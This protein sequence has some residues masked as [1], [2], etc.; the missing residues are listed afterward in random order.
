[1]PL[2][3]Q[4]ALNFAQ[5]L[6]WRSVRVLWEQPAN[7]WNYIGHLVHR[8]SEGKCHRWVHFASC[9]IL[10]FCTRSIRIFY[11]I[12]LTRTFSTCF[13]GIS[14]L[15]RLMAKSIEAIIIWNK[16]CRLEEINTYHKSNHARGVNPKRSSWNHTLQRDRRTLPF[17]RE[18][19]TN[20]V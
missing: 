1:M 14:E 10:Y 7:V 8:G 19:P 16:I 12:A 11:F 20:H 2:K 6:W 18:S 5:G 15:N 4:A 17:S 3:N 13:I 9:F